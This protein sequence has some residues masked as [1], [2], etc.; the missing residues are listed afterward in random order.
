MKVHGDIKGANFVVSGDHTP[1]LT[2]FGNSAINRCSLQFTT[3]EDLSKV[4]APEILLGQTKHTFEGDVYALGMT[5]LEIMTGSVPWDGML[6]V[7]VVGNLAQK[8]HPARPVIYI[9]D[10][11][12][13]LMV[14]CWANEPQRRPLAAKVRDELNAINKQ[15]QLVNH[16]AIGA[17]VV[18]PSKAQDK[19]RL[20]K[21]LIPR[22]PDQ[23]PDSFKTNAYRVG[24][25]VEAQSTVVAVAS[26]IGLAHAQMLPPN[27]DATDSLWKRLLSHS[28]SD[29]R[30]TSSQAPG[31]QQ[32]VERLSPDA[33]VSQNTLNHRTTHFKSSNR[34]SIMPSSST[35]P[36][37]SGIKRS[38]KTGHGATKQS[39]GVSVRNQSAGSL[40]LNLGPVALTPPKTQRG[41]QNPPPHKTN[42]VIQPIPPPP[43]IRSSRYSSTQTN[44]VP[45]PMTQNRRRLASPLRRTSFS[46]LTTA[47][48]NISAPTTGL[49]SRVPHPE[50]PSDSP[51]PI[52]D[53]YRL[54]RAHS[55]Q[56]SSPRESVIAHDFYDDLWAPDRL[57]ESSPDEPRPSTLNS[58]PL[59]EYPSRKA[60]I[61]HSS[62]R[63]RKGIQENSSSVSLDGLL[64]EFERLEATFREL[65]YS[66]ETVPEEKGFDRKRILNWVAHFVDHAMA[67]DVRAIVFAGNVHID[68]ETL[69][70]IPPECSKASEAITCTEWEQ[71][72]RDNARPGV[73]ILSIMVHNRSGE[74]MKQEFDRQ[75]WEQPELMKPIKK[76]DPIYL[77]FAAGD[78]AVYESWVT[79]P[80]QP[81]RTG[82]HFVHALVGAI[83]SVDAGTGT[84]SEF[85]EAFDR[86]FRRARSCAS[87]QEREATGTPNWRSSHQQIPRFSASEFV[88]LSAIF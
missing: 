3:T 19:G 44:I 8:L 26:L 52:S 9:P 5:I 42:S 59:V 88:A 11:L 13:E 46:S 80:P 84:W 65:G 37:A 14:S 58:S 77:T 60:L 87:L 20:L 22:I 64:G 31:Q 48:S 75:I 83:R 86:H 56:A 6:D 2:D 29:N 55:F 33:P 1:K 78:G 28:G 79:R 39:K 82:E 72:I 40:L 54:G 57:A 63:G 35:I 53:L 27:I 73:V 47:S 62:Y 66:I 24:S 76:E 74:V 4:T 18:G 70:L 81:V 16:G 50:I 32:P 61:I 36:I 43:P 71:N 25:T 38:D 85:F 68:N 15:R 45:D 49:S 21:K 34:S 51:Y 17:D 7:T 41:T 67:G 12:W 10:P 23:T 69:S 30:Q